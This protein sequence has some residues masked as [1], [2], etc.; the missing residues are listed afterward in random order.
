MNRITRE[1]L[2][3]RCLG[4]TLVILISQDGIGLLRQWVGIFYNRFRNQKIQRSPAQVLNQQKN[5]LISPFP[6]NP[7]QKGS[8]FPPICHRCLVN[9]LFGL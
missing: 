5:L 2:Q 1:L 4:L 7:H 3:K 6:Q 8:P 9:G